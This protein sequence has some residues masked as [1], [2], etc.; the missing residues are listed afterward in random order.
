MLSRRLGS[1]GGALVLLAGLA[2]TACGDDDDGAP[3]DEAGSGGSSAGTSGGGGSSAGSGGSGASGAGS[4]GSSTAGS[5]GTGG[6]AGSRA[7]S[8]GTGG[9]T[10]SGQPIMCD[11][12]DCTAMCD[13]MRNCTVTC[14]GECEWDSPRNNNDPIPTVT[15]TCNADCQGECDEE[16]GTCNVTCNSDCEIDCEAATCNI[17]CGTTAATLCPDGQTYVCG[18]TQCEEGDDE[19]DAGSR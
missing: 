11:Q 12:G 6:S 18:T 5:G 14:A 10:S 8:G 16:V 15:A 4:G 17:K 7:G 19:M 9:S 1:I 2:L 13:A 3:A